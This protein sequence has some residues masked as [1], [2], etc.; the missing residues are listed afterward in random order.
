MPTKNKKFI[1]ISDEAHNICKKSDISISDY[2]TLAILNFE[3]LRKINLSLRLQ[4]SEL[5]ANLLS[6]RKIPGFSIYY[7][8]PNY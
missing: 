4:N 2:A 8:K 5:R 7:L 6:L 3:H 1:R